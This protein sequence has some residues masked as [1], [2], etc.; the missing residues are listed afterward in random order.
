[1]LDTLKATLAALF[2]VIALW[3]SIEG[4]RLFDDMGQRL[5]YAAGWI[6]LLPLSLLLAGALLLA[7]WMLLI[8]VGIWEG[9]T[10][11]MREN[12]KGK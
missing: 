5:A 3:A 8:G 6:V 11:V 9:V 12:R 10:Q 1:M 4:A 7:W 2:L